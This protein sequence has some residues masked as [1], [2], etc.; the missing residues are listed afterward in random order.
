M[1]DEDEAAILGYTIEHMQD[2]SPK[3]TARK[4]F[5]KTKVLDLVGKM[6]DSERVKYYNTACL[7]TKFGEWE[8][9]KPWIMWTFN[10][11][12]GKFKELWTLPDY[13]PSTP[14]LYEART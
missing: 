11:V 1:K 2:T 4:E 13:Y 14:D 12:D 10:Y 5:L 6:K 3:E 9:A 8:K 7:L